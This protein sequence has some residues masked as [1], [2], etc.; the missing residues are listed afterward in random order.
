MDQINNLPWQAIL[1]LA[2]LAWIGREGFG[3]YWKLRAARM[4]E[5]SEG[6]KKHLAGYLELIGELKARVGHLEGVLGTMESRHNQVTAALREEHVAC[7][8]A[9]A[10]Q[11][12]KIAV[13]EDEV[14]GLRDWRHALANQAQTAANIAAAKDKQQ[15]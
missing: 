10:Q 4:A 13:L 1:A 12:A 7:L 6:D 9:Q 3:I 15:E 14:K 5:Q 8:K 11:S 2:V